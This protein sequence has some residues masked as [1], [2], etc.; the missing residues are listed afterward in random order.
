MSWH[1]TA[2]SHLLPIGCLIIVGDQAYHC[3][4]VSKLKDGVGVVLGQA[5]MGVEEGTKYA[6][7]R[8]PNV[9]D[10][11]IRNVVAYPYHLG[12]SRQEVQDAVA[13]GHV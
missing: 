8:G 11:R 9:E 4:I 7:L 10:Q 13:E 2:R 1:H 6:P 12:A 3:C 5:V